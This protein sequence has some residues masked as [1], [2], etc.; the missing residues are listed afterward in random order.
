MQKDKVRQKMKTQRLKGPRSLKVK[1]SSKGFVAEEQRDD[2]SAE[3]KRHGSD[4]PC[5]I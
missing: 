1:H 2:D 4:V 3:N 5:V